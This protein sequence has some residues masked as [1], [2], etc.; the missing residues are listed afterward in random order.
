MCLDFVL[1]LSSRASSSVMRMAAKCLDDARKNL[2]RGLAARRKASKI[3]RPPL[4]QR[5]A[6]RGSSRSTVSS[7]T[8]LSQRSSTQASSR[9]GM[10]SG[11]SSSAH[12]GMGLFA[13][14]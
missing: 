6:T 9:S 4:S 10:S 13:F 12:A 14:V 11:M 2:A 3:P 1:G 8:P 5:S 7:G